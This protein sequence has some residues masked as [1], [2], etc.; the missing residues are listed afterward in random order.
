MTEKL[1]KDQQTGILAA[2]DEALEKAPWGATKFLSLLGNKLQKIR[3]E[4]ADTLDVD[5]NQIEKKSSKLNQQARIDRFAKMK[6]LYIALYAFDG[7]N[8]QSWERILQHLPNQVISRPVYEKEEDAIASIRSK[9]NRF[10]EAYVS[11]YVDP[12]LI[13]PHPVEKIAVDKLGVQ[14]LGLKAKAINLDNMDVF[15]HQSGTYTFLNG[16]LIKQGVF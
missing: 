5:D 6:K 14:L 12:Q 13:L 3:D 4:V 8:I 9:S 7:S 16:R 11:I 10:N 2:L 1:T 15:I